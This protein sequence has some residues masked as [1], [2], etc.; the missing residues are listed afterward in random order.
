VKV[1][2]K[3]LQNLL[4]LSKIP[5][6]SPFGHTAYYKFWV[7]INYINLIQI[8]YCSFSL[9]LSL[10]FFLFVSLCLSLLYMYIYNWFIQYIYNETYT[11]RINVSSM[12][13]V[14]RQEGSCPNLKVRTGNKRQTLSTGAMCPAFTWLNASCRGTP[15]YSSTSSQH[16]QM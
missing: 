12:A 4:C 14:G 7:H 13:K 11:I 3:H 9:P 8:I 6:F 16:N 15:S 10:F 1:L 5:N 2:T